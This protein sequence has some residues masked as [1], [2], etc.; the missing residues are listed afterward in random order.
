MAEGILRSEMDKYGIAAIVD[1]AGT[2]ASHVGDQ[3]DQR[4]IRTLAKHNI[5]IS[6]LSARQ[7]TAKDF[8]E[9]DIIF[10]MDLSNLMNIIGLAR[11]EDDRKKVAMYLDILAPGHNRSVPDPYYGGIEGFEEVYELLKSATEKFI[12]TL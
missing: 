4:A 11:N 8:D 2:S 3:P 12:K 7:F 1:S 5:D 10:A 6:G 9:F